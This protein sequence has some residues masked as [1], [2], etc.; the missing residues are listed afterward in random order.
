MKMVIIGGSSFSTPGLLNFLDSNGTPRGMEVV[1]ASRSRERLAAVKRAAHF[2]ARGNLEIKTE[3][4]E[5]NN[6]SEILD[7]AEIVVIQIR[8]GGFDGRLFDE[9]FPNRY[10]LCGDEGL[11]AGGVSAGWGS[12]PV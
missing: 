3:T 12:W 10:G 11:G 8:V 4:T 9:T 2:L 7:G 5:S 1:L 6:W